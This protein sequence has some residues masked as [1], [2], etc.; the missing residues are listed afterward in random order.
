[1]PNRIEREIEEI[2]TRLDEFVPNEP[3]TRRARRRVDRWWGGV[4]GWFG[5]RGGGFTGGHAVLIAAIVLV[6]AFFL[7]SVVPTLAKYATWAALLVIFAAIFFSIRPRRRGQQRYWRGQPVD[8]RRPS[9]MTQLRMWWR[10]RNRG[11]F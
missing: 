1:M 5:S 10:R 8:L 7:Q 2:L 3:R 11:R 6:A 4:R 9:P